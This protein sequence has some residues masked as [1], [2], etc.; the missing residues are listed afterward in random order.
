MGNTFPRVQVAG[1]EGG[2]MQDLWKRLQAIAVKNGQSLHL[3]PP[4]KES[5]IAAAEKTM[6]LKFPADLRASLLLHDGQEDEAT[7]Q[8]MIGCG[9]L[10]PLEAI[11]AQWTEERDLDEDEGGVNY[12]GGADEDDEEDEDDEDDDEDDD[13]DD[14]DDDEE[15]E[16]DDDDEESDIESY[17]QNFL[18]H[19]KRIP[20]AGTPYWDGDNTYVDLA[21]ASDGKSG[22]LI[23]MISESTFVLLDD[24]FRGAIEHYIKELETGKIV[25]NADEEHVVPKKKKRTHGAEYFAKVK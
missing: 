12:A 4:A 24:S 10:A 2:N 7:F 16:D 9:R 8:W 1:L 6:K 18:W 23:T 13:D 25:W 20:I 11:V 14:E 5:A 15:E 17:V 22:Q 21:P 19:P 3:R